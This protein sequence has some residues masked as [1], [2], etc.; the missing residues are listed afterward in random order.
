MS[1]G[2]RTQL[3]ILLL[4]I[5]DEA[6]TRREELE[7]FAL[8]SGLQPEQIEILNLFDQPRFD[9]R[10]VLDYDALF[11]GGSS[12][13]SVLEPARY[14]FV[15]AAEALLRFCIAER[16][17]VFASCFGHQ[18]AVTALGGQVVRD[19]RDFEMGTLPIFLTPAA[20]IDPLYRGVPSGFLAVSVHRERATAVPA[21]CQLLAYTQAC[22][23][24]FKV[25]GAPFWTTQF[26]PEVSRA[27]LIERLTVFKEKYTDGD[28][29]LRQVLENAAETPDSNGLLRLFVDRVLLAG[30]QGW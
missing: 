12:E 16:V 14:P 19:E 18:L 15:P 24:S 6:R 29:H 7:S 13:A 22:I 2:R 3:R 23:H 1:M 11:V 28:D 25:R 27:I 26:H 9:P 21:G 5:R 4:Q 17:P 8:F 10:Q 20:A 30:E